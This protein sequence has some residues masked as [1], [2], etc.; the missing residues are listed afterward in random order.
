[1]TKKEILDQANVFTPHRTNVYAAMDRWADIKVKEVEDKWIH[2]LEGTG[3]TT[4]TQ[5]RDEAIEV[6]DLIVPIMELQ[7]KG[8]PGLWN[9]ALIT[10]AKE[11]LNRDKQWYTG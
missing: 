8:W 3:K 9:Y 4:L 5:E 1:M 7:N 11:L 10:R 6:L 2:Y